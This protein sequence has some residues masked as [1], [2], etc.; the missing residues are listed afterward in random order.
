M[1]T[2]ITALILISSICV[3]KAQTPKASGPNDLI[4]FFEGS[5]KGEGSF[6]S[7]KKIS[8]TVIFKLSL[9]SCWLTCTHEDLLPNRYKAVSMWSVDRSKSTF[10]VD[11]FDN[12]HSHRIFTGTQPASDQII[13]ATEAKPFQRF[14]Y[15][16]LDEHHFKMVYEVSKDGLTW[17]LGDSLTFTQNR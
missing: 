2:L 17:Q 6:A 8:A 9:D 7:G 1:K 13:I 5:W 16:K 10:A 4:R 11:I 12:F 15:T 3:L 14:I